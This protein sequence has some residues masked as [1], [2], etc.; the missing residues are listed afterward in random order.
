MASSMLVLYLFGNN[1]AQ[2]ISTVIFWGIAFG[3]LPISV[4]GCLIAEAGNRMEQIQS[5]HVGIT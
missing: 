4:Q 2:A 3:M 5:L 1:P